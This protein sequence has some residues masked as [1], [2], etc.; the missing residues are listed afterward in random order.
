MRT[1]GDVTS[2]QEVSGMSQVCMRSGEIKGRCIGI[3]QAM[4]NAVVSEKPDGHADI[5]RVGIKEPPREMVG[6]SHEH[7]DRLSH[8]TAREGV[9]DV[10]T[11]SKAASP[12]KAYRG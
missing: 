8:E 9:S 2:R 11:A 12:R 1:M 10:L 4:A 6:Q 5:N 7:R 3:D